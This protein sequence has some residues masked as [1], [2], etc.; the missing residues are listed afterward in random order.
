MDY[1]LNRR[2]VREFDLTKEISLEELK[3]LCKYGEAAPSARNQKSREYIIIND[4]KVIED[5][6]TVSKGAG[7]LNRCNTAIAVIAR[8]EA[9]ITTP[10]ML[11][12]DLS[13]AVENILISATKMGYGSC[14][15]G[16]HPLEDRVFACDK[17][18]NVTGGAHTFALIALGYCETTAFYDKDKFDEALLHINRY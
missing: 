6:A 14:Y 13:C 3:L 11:E 16:I 15:I 7:V 2:S 5:L 10:S 12:Q 8:N 4:R 18:L 9:F 17:I 1:I